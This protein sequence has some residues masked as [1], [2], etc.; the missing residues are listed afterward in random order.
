MKLLG[1]IFSVCICTLILVSS[2]G[3]NS[4]LMFKEAKGAKIN[5]SIPLTPTEDY[6][7]SQDDKFSFTLTTKNGTRIIEDMS[8]ISED[9]REVEAGFE[10]VVRQNGEAKLPI[11]GMVKVAGLTIAECED[12]LEMK[13]GESFLDPF[14]QLRVTNQRVIVFPGNGSDAKVIPLMNS[15]T[16][17]MEALA[18]AGGITDRG[19]ANSIKLMRKVNGERVIYTLDLSTIE[20]LKYVDMIIQANDYIYVEPTP[21]LAKEISE[22]IVPIVSLITSALIIFSAILVLK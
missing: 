10:Y 11:I 20:G 6:K 7:I 16:T 22:D 4:N 8:G 9:S 18:Q 13:Y 15:N 14:I 5:D 1:R 19:K 21:E 2:C 12:L 17:L 3:V